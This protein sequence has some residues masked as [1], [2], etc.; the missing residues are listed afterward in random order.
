MH[1]IYYMNN[2]NANAHT[3]PINENL[4]LA[5][6]NVKRSAACKESATLRGEPSTSS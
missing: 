6:R 1:A 4:H 3:L 2:N 5:A